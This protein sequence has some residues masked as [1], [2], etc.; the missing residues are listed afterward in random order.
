MRRDTSVG[1]LRAEKRRLGLVARSNV[2]GRRLR[3]KCQHLPESGFE[4]G[5][6]AGR[7]LVSVSVSGGGMKVKSWVYVLAARMVF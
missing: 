1:T 3:R 4:S 2:G 6:S 7:R 5:L